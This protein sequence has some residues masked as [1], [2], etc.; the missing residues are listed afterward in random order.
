MKQI[1][2]YEKK[3]SELI[4]KLD[5]ETYQAPSMI[6]GFDDWDYYNKAMNENDLIMNKIIQYEK[7]IKKA[8]T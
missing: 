3:I 5:L 4:G 1:E 8:R 2:L 7:L 6:Q